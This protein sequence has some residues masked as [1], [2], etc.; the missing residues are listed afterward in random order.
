MYEC[1]SVQVYELMSM[2]AS[3]CIVYECV[4]AVYLSIRVFE[5]LRVSAFERLSL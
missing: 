3:E 2:R 5:G 1:M 4:V